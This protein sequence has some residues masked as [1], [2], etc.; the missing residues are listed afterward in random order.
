[1]Y[2]TFGRIAEITVYAILNFLPYLALALYPFRNNLRYSGGKTALL[3]VLAT[4]L[5]V[6]FGLQAAFSPVSGTGILS[7]LSTTVYCLLYFWAVKA[8]PGKLL[9]TLLVLSNIAN[10]TVV[11]SKCIEGQI[12]P[13]LAVQSYRWSFSAVMAVVQ[14]A[15]LIPLFFYCRNIYA[16][17]V[18][19]DTDISSWK[20][21]WLAPATFY[22][23]WFYH[24]YGNTQSSLEIALQP[25]HALFLLAINAG[26][27]LI[28]HIIVQLINEYD[29]NS[30]LERQ[31]HILTLEALQYKNLQE[32][33]RETQQARHDL[34]HH[35]TVMTGLLNEGNSEKLKAYLEGYRKSLPDDTSVSFCRN[36]TVNLLLQYFSQQA[37]LAGIPFTA[38][39]DI[40]ENPPIAEHDLAVLLGNLLENAVNACSA[41]NSMERRIT[42]RGRFENNFLVFTIDNTFDGK[43][44]PSEDGGYLSAKRREPGIGLSSARHIAARY[45]GILRT[46]QKNGIFYASVLLYLK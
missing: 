1:M 45:K 32:K 21:L 8:H 2:D 9:F 16:G 7:A 33:I 5:Q 26:A 41:Q 24:I 27:L 38:H 12:F 25:V 37:G 42:F 15:T 39:A 23:L 14:L 4:L 17:V 11:C 46:E 18:E 19:M 44:I 6:L 36:S 28:Y 30:L 40:P 22:L 35:I 20:Y 43:L 29:R 13:A 10:C 31:N 3:T 34:R